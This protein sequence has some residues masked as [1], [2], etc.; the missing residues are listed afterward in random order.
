M[1]E[2]TTLSAYREN[3]PSGGETPS[4]HDAGLWPD[5][6]LYTGKRWG[7]VIDLARCTGCSACVVACQAENNVPVVGR[8]EVRRSREMHWIRIDR[9]YSDV[10]DGADT[11]HQPMLCHHCENA[12]CENVCP[13][14]ATVHSEEGLSQQVY[15]RCVGTRYC[16][17]NCPYKVRRFNW[18]RYARDD[19][20]E[21]LV[22]NPDVTV[23]CRGVME[24][25]SFCAQRIQ[26][27]KLEAKRLGRELADGEIQPACQQ[28]CPARAIVFGDLNDP[29]SRVSQLVASPRYYQVL[30][31]LNIRPAIGYLRRVRNREAGE[32]G[33]QHG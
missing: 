32:G 17:N 8:D 6:H 1:I 3:S 2:E 21:N 30:A 5:D 18:F 27:A 33:T 12:P 24:K 26:E 7:M 29:K 13:V 31:E 25:C 22:L 14:L 4:E 19:Q 15:N 10:A 28:S 11:A 9:Y 20:R 16:A 23:R